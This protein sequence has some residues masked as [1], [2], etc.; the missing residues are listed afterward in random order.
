M[1][2]AIRFFPRSLHFPRSVYE[3][4]SNSGF[5]EKVRSKSSGYKSP[6]ISLGTI[7]QDSVAVYTKVFQIFLAKEKELLSLLVYKLKFLIAPFH[8]P[9]SD[10]VFF[11]LIYLSGWSFLPRTSLAGRTFVPRYPM[12]SYFHAETHIAEDFFVPLIA[13]SSIRYVAV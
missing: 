13:S 7:T 11:S 3:L 5:W 6:F 2:T 4:R 9:T 8:S 1:N 10:F 12:L